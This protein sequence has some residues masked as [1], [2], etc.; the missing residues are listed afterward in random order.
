MGSI[1]K[2]VSL[3]FDENDF[4]TDYQLSPTSLLK[5]KIWEMKGAVK[6]LVQNKIDRMSNIIHEQAARINQMEDVLEQKEDITLE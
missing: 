6:K 4:L 3:T 1:I 2:S 5:E